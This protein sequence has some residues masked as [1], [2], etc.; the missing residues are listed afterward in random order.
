M[1]GRDERKVCRD[2]V[3]FCRVERLL[4]PVGRTWYISALVLE[5][6]K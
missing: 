2:A 6:K 3:R 5:R 1:L 4:G